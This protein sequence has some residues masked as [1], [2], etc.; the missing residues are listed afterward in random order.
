M[1]LRIVI[2]NAID[3]PKKITNVKQNVLVLIDIKV[4]KA[5]LNRELYLHSKVDI[6]TFAVSGLELN[7]FQLQNF[8]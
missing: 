7:H 4:E 1:N 3:A 2:W 6:K 5:N 8:K